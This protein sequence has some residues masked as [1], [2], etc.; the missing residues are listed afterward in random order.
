MIRI[1]EETVPPLAGKLHVERVLYRKADNKAYFSLLCDV[2]VPE[3]DFLTLERR[4]RG[5]FPKMQVALRVASP[6]LKEDFKEKE[7]LIKFYSN[8]NYFIDSTKYFH[9]IDPTEV[10]SI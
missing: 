7:P 5:L 6:A 4:L 9:C 8:K 3:R 1:L 10:S 2:L